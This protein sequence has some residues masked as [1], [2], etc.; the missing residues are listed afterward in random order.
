MNVDADNIDVFYTIL[1]E[2]ESIV[3]NEV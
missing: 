3:G 2:W 1:V